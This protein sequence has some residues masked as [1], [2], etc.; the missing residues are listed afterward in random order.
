MCLFE[1]GVAQAK[2]PNWTL[3]ESTTEHRVY[4]DTNNIK[5]NGD[6]VYFWNIFDSNKTASSTR[7]YSLIDC[8]EN[9]IINKE[10]MAFD[11]GMAQGNLKFIAKENE[12]VKVY[13]S[14]GTVLD[15]FKDRLCKGN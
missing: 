6:M 11:R 7:S 5:R 8:G 2:N 12:Q 9:S 1:I 13:I 14:P 15:K 3:V 4:M 10:T